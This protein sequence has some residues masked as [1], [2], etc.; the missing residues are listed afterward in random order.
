MALIIYGRLEDKTVQE[1]LSSG[2]AVQ[3]E[4]DYLAAQANLADNIEDAVVMVAITYHVE[5]PTDRHIRL[6]ASPFTLDIFDPPRPMALIFFYDV[7]EYMMAHTQ[8][9]D[10]LANASHELK[11]PVASLRTHA[12]PD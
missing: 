10:F 7:T 9:A 5:D 1:N 8:R 12:A 3:S 4:E 2:P 11:T 6:M